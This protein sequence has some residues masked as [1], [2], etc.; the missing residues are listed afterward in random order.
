MKI[1]VGMAGIFLSE[2]GF[3]ALAGDNTLLNR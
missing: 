3:N 1:L 2:N